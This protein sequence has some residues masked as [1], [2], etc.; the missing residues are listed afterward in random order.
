MAAKP[1]DRPRHFYSLDEYF[2][3]EH[4]SDARFEYWDGDIVCMTGGSLAHGRIAGN[5]Y[6]RLRLKLDGGPC[7]AF[8]AETPI[9]TPSLLPYRYP[10][11][12]VVCG[13]PEIENMRGIEALLNPVLVVEVLSPGTERLDRG[14][15]FTAYKVVSTLR[16]YLLVAQDAPRVTRYARQP[17]GSWTHEDVAGLD[18][19]L[20]LACVGCSLPLREIYEGVNLRD[21]P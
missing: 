21:M 14:D 10:D 4:A 7:L 8:N 5:I 17:D 12:S 20:I 6:H 3:L 13:E 15:K 18:A 1:D 9:K 2:A 16:E 19:V 11:V